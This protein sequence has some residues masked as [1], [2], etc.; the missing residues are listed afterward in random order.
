MSQIRR[1]PW[2]LTTALQAYHTAQR[3]R[4]RPSTTWRLKPSSSNRSLD[5][6]AIPTVAAVHAALHGAVEQLPGNDSASLH[7]SK[8]NAL[9][10]PMAARGSQGQS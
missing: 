7:P 8:A 10:S 6:Y 4:S 2:C 1:H 5:G 9:L 3:H